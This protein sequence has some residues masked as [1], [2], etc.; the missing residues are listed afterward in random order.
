MAYHAVRDTLPKGDDPAAPGRV[1]RVL[2]VLSAPPR[3]TPST[4]KPPYPLV[5][6][7][8]SGVMHTTGE[9]AQYA[10]A[11][12]ALSTVCARVRVCARG[13]ALQRK[14]VTKLV[15]PGPFCAM[16]TPCLLTGTHRPLNEYSS[17]TQGPFCARHTRQLHAVVLRCARA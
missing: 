4:W 14:P 8:A 10:A 13:C 9:C 12:P 16:H 11:T 1:Q 7:P 3:G 5:A 2:T 6:E 15:M 17:G